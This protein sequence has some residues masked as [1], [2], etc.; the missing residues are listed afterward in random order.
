MNL[1]SEFEV[2]GSFGKENTCT[3]A[4]SPDHWSVSSY[5]VWKNKEIK[6]GV[7]DPVNY[8]AWS[9]QV[10]LPKSFWEWNCSVIESVW[11]GVYQ[12]IL[13]KT[14]SGAGEFSIASSAGHQSSSS[15]IFEHRS[16]IGVV[17]ESCPWLQMS[18]LSQLFIRGLCFKYMLYL[19]T[20]KGHTKAYTW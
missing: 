8:R 7:L 12:A 1:E 18:Y 5:V 9:A 3:K 15:L 17:C 16:F 11:V 19:W 13:L 14:S 2:Q 20:R 4:F 10:C 6:K